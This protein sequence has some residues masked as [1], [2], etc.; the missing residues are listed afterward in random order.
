MSVVDGAG[1][2]IHFEIQLVSAALLIGTAPGVH[3]GNPWACSSRKPAWV[4][5]NG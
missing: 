3:H 4:A 5:R 2:M 1:W